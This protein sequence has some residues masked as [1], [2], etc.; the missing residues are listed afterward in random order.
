MSKVIATR[1]KN[2][3]PNIIH[4]N[5][6]GYVKDRY[7]AETIRLVF[8]IMNFTAKESIPGLMIFI[9]FEKAFDSV[10]WEFLFYCLK[11][12]NFGPNFTHWVQ[13]ILGDPG[14]VSRGRAKWRDESFQERAEEP[15]GTKSH[16][17]ISK[18]LCEY[19]LLIGQNNIYKGL[20]QPNQEPVFAKPFGN[21]P[22][23]LGT[24]GFFRPL[25]KTFVA[26][27]RPP[28][29]DCPWVSEDGFKRSTET[30]KAV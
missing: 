4:H 18:R 7:I 2:V 15:L 28:P 5:Q 8:D 29:T 20:F 14:A 27:F 24:Q 1:I 17:T 16:R 30:Y 19:R 9:D 3:H 6:T 22:V 11:S 23:R 12:F 10:E 21:G 13:T 26:P 25:L